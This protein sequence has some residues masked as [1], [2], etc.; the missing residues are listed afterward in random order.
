MVM[1]PPQ[2]RIGELARRVGTTP[3]AVRYYEE[4]GLLP[5]SHRSDGAHRVYDEQDEARLRDLLRVRELLGLTLVELREWMDAEDARARLRERWNEQPA[6]DESTRADIIREAIAH[7]DTQLLLVRSRLGSL[8]QL[9][10][11]LSAKRR[12]VRSMLAEIEQAQA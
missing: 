3:R 7:M 6:P 1:T 9:E 8:E 11:E 5:G 12:K 4:L 10:D 2:F